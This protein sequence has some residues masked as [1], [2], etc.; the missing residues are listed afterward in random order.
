MNKQTYDNISML[1]QY[2]L[3]SNYS[4]TFERCILTSLTVCPGESNRAPA[5]VS[6]VFLGILCASSSILARMTR[7][8]ADICEVII[9][10]VDGHHSVI[11]FILHTIQHPASDNNGNFPEPSYPTLTTMPNSVNLERSKHGG[12]G[13]IFVF[14]ISAIITNSTV[15]FKL[16]N[17]KFTQINKFVTGNSSQTCL[18]SRFNGTTTNLNDSFSFSS[19]SFARAG[20]IMVFIGVDPPLSP[21][22]FGETMNLNITKL[23]EKI[24]FQSPFRT[25]SHTVELFR[26]PHFERVQRR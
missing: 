16:Y 5:T 15:K 18:I 9:N 1:R 23:L 4:F 13:F 24:N 17:S 6:N 25:V 3:F 21:T 19:S 12:H 20:P 2:I 26:F 14:I 10:I 8:F 7:T 22:R 11:N